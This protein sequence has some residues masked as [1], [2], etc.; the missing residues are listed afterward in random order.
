M[1][2]L[3]GCSGESSETTPKERTAGNG[4]SGGSTSK[5]GTKEESKKDV[6]LLSDELVEEDMSTKVVGEVK[7]TSGNKQSYVGVE[8][9]FKNSEGTRVGE[10]LDNT[11]ELP[12]GQTWAFE[13]MYLGEES[14]E[15]YTIKASTSSF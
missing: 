14:V 11:T 15:S 8:V 2:A 10:G 1:T 4:N 5:Q 7:N 6:K 9:K 13:A 12:A 3:A